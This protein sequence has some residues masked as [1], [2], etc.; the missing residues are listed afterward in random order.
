MTLGWGLRKGLLCAHMAVNQ[1]VAH[2]STQYYTCP[3]LHADTIGVGFHYAEIDIRRGTA[4]D[5]GE[6]PGRALRRSSRQQ[7]T[8]P[9]FGPI[10]FGRRR[11]QIP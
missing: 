11:Q 1:S 2:N 3:Q 9:R 6:N 4:R 7:Q 8:N 5:G 10:A